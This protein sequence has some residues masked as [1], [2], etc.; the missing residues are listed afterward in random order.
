MAVLLAGLRWRYPGPPST[1]SAVRDGGGLRRGATI[2]AGDADVCPGRGSESMTRAPFVLGRFRRPVPRPWTWPTPGWAGGWWPRIKEM[3]PPITLGETAE[4][5]AAK[6]GITRERQDEWALRS[7]QLA[8]AR[9]TQAG[10]TP[11][12]RRSPPRAARSGTTRGSTTSHPRGPGREGAGLPPGRYSHRRNSSPL[13]DGAAALLLM[14]A[15]RCAGRRD[16]A[17]PLRGAAAAA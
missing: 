11:R 3:Y 17:G 13:N 12:R 5:V 14:S 6:Y 16:A 7:H 2:A 8:A 1:G 9:A 10:S 15:T 4:N